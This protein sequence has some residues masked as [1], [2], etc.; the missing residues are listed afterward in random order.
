MR[1]KPLTLD[2]FLAR[3]LG[4]PDLMMHNAHLEEPGFTTL[5]VRYLQHAIFGRSRGPMLDLASI[6]VSEPGK[7]TFTKL[8]KRIRATYPNLSIRV[9]NA[10]EE[11]FQKYL[12]KNGFQYLGE[13][14]SFFL[15]A[16]PHR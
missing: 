5:Y 11:R 9:E 14:P 12:T 15:D 2:R 16:R 7:G 6:T 1:D 4:E 8:V 3:Q 10:L 13:G